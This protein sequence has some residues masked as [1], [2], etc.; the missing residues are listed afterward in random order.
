M[1]VSIDT[2]KPKGKTQVK[3]QDDQASFA[4]TQYLSGERVY[5]NLAGQSEEKNQLGSTIQS[6]LCGW[7]QRKKERSQPLKKKLQE[8]Y[9]KEKGSK[10]ENEEKNIYRYNILFNKLAQHVDTKSLERY[11]RKSD[12]KDSDLQ[13]YQDPVPL[14]HKAK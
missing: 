1:Q 5:H 2:D 7:N 10:F 12:L 6:G 13:E 9:K 3:F 8:A 4:Q 11:L 14:F